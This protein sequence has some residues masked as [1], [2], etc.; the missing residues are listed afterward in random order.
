[1]HERDLAIAGESGVVIYLSLDATPLPTELCTFAQQA[2]KSS[3]F[4]LHRQD[5]SGSTMLHVLCDGGDPTETEHKLHQVL[6][7]AS[8]ADDFWVLPVPDK[9]GR[10]PLLL[11]LEKNR[12]QMCSLLLDAY[13]AHSCSVALMNSLAT[14]FADPNDHDKCHHE[15]CEQLCRYP[16]LMQTILRN[17]IVRSAAPP[18]PIGKY[19]LN[20]RV[21][22]RASYY[23]HDIHIWSDLQLHQED[24][25]GY[26]APVQC[27]SLVLAIPSLLSQDGLFHKLCDME[28]QDRLAIFEL[29][30][31]KYVIDYKWNTYGFYIHA[32]LTALY[33]LMLI[34]FTACCQ[35][36]TDEVERSQIIIECCAA[37]GCTSQN[38]T[39]IPCKSKKCGEASFNCTYT[40]DLLS[41][42]DNWSVPD[43][44][45]VLM[46]AASIISFIFAFKELQEGMSSGLKAYFSSGWNFLDLITYTCVPVTAVYTTYRGAKGAIDPEK[47]YPMMQHEFANLVLSISAI[48]VW[49]NLTAFLRPYTITGPFV[50]MVI[51]VIIDMKAFMTL[52]IIYWF[53]FG[54]AF[55]TLLARNPVWNGWA[56]YINVFQMIF[57]Q[58][59]QADYQTWTFDR[60]ESIYTDE[61]QHRNDKNKRL[62]VLLGNSTEQGRHLGPKLSYA[63]GQVY[64]VFY[65]V[66]IGI[67][68]LNLLIAIMGHAYDK[69]R[70][71]QAVRARMDRADI[72]AQLDSIYASQ[73]LMV[74]NFIMKHWQK[75][76][77]RDGDD[78]LTRSRPQQTSSDQSAESNEDLKLANAVYP[79]F[80]HI[81]GSVELL[82]DSGSLRSDAEDSLD[83][84]A[85]LTRL[86]QMEDRLGETHSSANALA[87]EMDAAEKGARETEEMVQ[88]ISK[89]LLKAASSLAM[90]SMQ[91]QQLATPRS[92]NTSPPVRF[93][94][95]AGDDRER[96]PPKYSPPR[97][98]KT[99]PGPVPQLIVS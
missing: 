29:D 73:I 28:T 8:E 67:V 90:E 66:M 71:K 74:W 48:W 47:Q 59:N 42:P 69:I 26:D 80:L 63:V 88:S 18:M 65:M 91:P 3:P 60:G 27:S 83:G 77:N 85:I 58:L 51:Q 79:K 89:F 78:A 14:L 36:F 94:Q 37:A 32:L 50:R 43:E 70:L 54:L 15:R 46:Y 20:Y 13:F 61:Y 62:S 84:Y 9:E 40:T 35:Q 1:M 6:T 86:Q 4:L 53:S 87:K 30:V 19:A 33:V 76:R 17:G 31:M 23:P 11:A 75:R 7:W 55:S 24:E 92:P 99:R 82:Q 68:L 95:V 49:L 98:L 96:R 44:S 72:I 21:H 10:I 2:V 22:V 97:P 64:F 5:E 34:L 12:H 39:S 93:G 45:R 25:N 16:D 52:M 57:G 56:G 41:F 38:T 81:L